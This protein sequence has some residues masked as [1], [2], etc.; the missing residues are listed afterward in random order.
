LYDSDTVERPFAVAF[1]DDPDVRMFFKIPSSFKIETPI[2][3]KLY[4]IRAEDL[5]S[6]E[7]QYETTRVI[8]YEES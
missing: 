4:R 5:E 8:S 7:R 1:D 3:G 2:G 6:F